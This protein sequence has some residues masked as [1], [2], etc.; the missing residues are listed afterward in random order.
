MRCA[1]SYRPRPVSTAGVNPGLRGC[2][3]IGLRRERLRKSGEFFDF[4]GKMPGKGPACGHEWLFLCARGSPERTDT[5][6]RFLERELDYILLRRG[7]L[8]RDAADF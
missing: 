6:Y 2:S 1:P 3:P 5:Q 7:D 8:K 4:R